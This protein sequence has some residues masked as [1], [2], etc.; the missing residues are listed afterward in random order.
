MN[1]EWM[2]LR[3]LHRKHR[4]YHDNELNFGRKVEDEDVV[5]FALELLGNEVQYEILLEWLVV[6]WNNPLYHLNHLYSL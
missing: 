5:V 3:F 2:F 6:V 4:E 1:Y